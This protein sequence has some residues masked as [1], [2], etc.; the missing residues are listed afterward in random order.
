MGCFR[1]C[2]CETFRPKRKKLRTEFWNARSFLEVLQETDRR[3]LSA[4]AFLH[5]SG[6]GLLLRIA[7]CLGFCLFLL[8]GLLNWLLPL[9]Q[10][11]AA[12]LCEVTSAP[13]VEIKPISFRY[14][15]AVV[16]HRWFAVGAKG[17]GFAAKAGDRP[18]N[19]A[20]GGSSTKA[21]NRPTS[22]FPLS[23]AVGRGRRTAAQ[24]HLSLL[25]GCP[26]A[27]G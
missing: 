20:W 10:S 12:P 9:V 2:R 11:A 24:V 3:R 14:C 13:P 23:I 22:I 4:A 19:I 1:I 16:T 17:L 7:C 26:P 6:L 25:G 21:N 18:L 5:Q 8:D 27:C 15:R